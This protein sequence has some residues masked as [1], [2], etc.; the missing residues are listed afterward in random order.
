ML[1]RP[2]QRC[3]SSR[4][5]KLAYLQSPSCLP[6]T[7]SWILRYYVPE[8]AKIFRTKPM[9]R[10]RVQHQKG[11]SDDAF[12]QL[13]PNEEA[14]RKAWLAW[15]WPEGFKCPRCAGSTY[16]EIRGRQLLQCRQCRHQTSLIAGTVLQGTKLPMRV[17]FRAMHLLAQG[18]KGLSNIELGRRLGIS[19]NAAWRIQHKLMQAMIERDRRYKMGAAGPRIEIDDAYI[20]GER[21][22]EGSGRGRRGHT[23]FIIAVETSTNGRPLYARLQ[24]VR[25]FQTGETKR[26]CA[27]IAA[28]T[29]IVSDGG[30]WFRCIAE[31]PGII[32]QRHITGSG[33]AS[34]R[35]PAFRWANTLLA[36]IKNSVLA[37]HR[38]VEAKH[39]PRYLGAFAWRFNRRWL[40]LG[41]GVMAAGHMTKAATRAPRRALPRRRALCTNSKKPRYSG[42][43]SCEMPRYGR[44]QERSKDH[45][46]S[47]V[48]TWISQ[49]PSP[50]SSRAYSPRAWQTVLCR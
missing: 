42:S 30:Q 40:L 7:L 26:L 19:T 4:C 33:R 24:V 27:R 23:P 9:P 44:S 37:T 11:L 13:Y 38:A 6:S 14:C 21:T 36:N 3:R 10:N 5:G 46:P 8:I 22:G 12:E 20:G 45:V 41:S 43:F 34:A 25:G 29:T 2:R 1:A 48:L 35:H 17:W 49:K 18:K 39:L 47:I 32:H 16:C 28:G 15:R 31:Q 50:S